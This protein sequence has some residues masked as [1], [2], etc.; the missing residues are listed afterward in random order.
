MYEGSMIG[1]G[2]NVFAVWN[3]VI[4]KNRSG[5]VEINPKLLA[6]TLGGM[7]KEAEEQVESA[8]KF[9]QRPDPKSR[10]KLDDGRRL[11][12]E[13]EYQYRLVNWEYYNRIRNEDDRREYNRRKQAEY[14]AKSKPLKNEVAAIL[15]ASNGDMAEHDRLA[16]EG[17]EP[18][19]HEPTR[20]TEEK[21]PQ[22]WGMT[23]PP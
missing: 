22:A 14:R 2:L 12:K 7:D 10:S 17:L 11:V 13:G 8:L 20:E 5:I 15:A 18:E 21:Y 3:Y 9:L 1:A 4:A 6:F 16:A 19:Y 23:R